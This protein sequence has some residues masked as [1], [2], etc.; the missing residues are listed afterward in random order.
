MRLLVKGLCSVV[1]EYPLGELTSDQSKL[2]GQ[3][4]GC[5]HMAEAQILELIDGLS[6]CLCFSTEG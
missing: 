3:D 5:C 2:S 1:D 4:L 6:A